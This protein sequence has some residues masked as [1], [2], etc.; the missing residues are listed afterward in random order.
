MLHSEL[1]IHSQCVMRDFL[2]SYTLS[3]SIVCLL[4]SFIFVELLGLGEY[5]LYVTRIHVQHSL[6][7]CEYR[8]LKL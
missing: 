1:Y 3:T 8:T 6:Q 5:V 2:F 4:C 7:T